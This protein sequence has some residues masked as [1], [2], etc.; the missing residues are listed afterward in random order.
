M[1]KSRRLHACVHWF[2]PQAPSKQ[3]WETLTPA[4]R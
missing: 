1:S 4:E 3:E 2:P